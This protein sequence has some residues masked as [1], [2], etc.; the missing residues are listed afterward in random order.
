M[1]QIEDDCVGCGRPCIGVACPYN[2]AP[3]WYCDECGTEYDP[4]ELY[5]FEGRD[6]CEECLKNILLDRAIQNGET[7][8]GIKDD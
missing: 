6:L 8:Q 1:K 7:E 5:R 3:H 4:S 2:A